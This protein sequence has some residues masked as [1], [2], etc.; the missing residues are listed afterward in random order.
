MIDQ[1]LCNLP[2]N[3]ARELTIEFNK[4]DVELALQIDEDWV[5]RG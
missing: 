1:E 5:Q 4:F 2:S 3:P